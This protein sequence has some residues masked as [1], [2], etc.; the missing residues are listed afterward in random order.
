MVLTY[1]RILKAKQSFYKFKLHFI[2]EIKKSR[3]LNNK[4]WDKYIR[5]F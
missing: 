5:C 1:E 4:L 3:L 2:R